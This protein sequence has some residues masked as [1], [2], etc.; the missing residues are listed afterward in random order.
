[1]QVGDRVRVARASTS[2]AMCWPAY[3]VGLTGVIIE[4]DEED[5]GE[6]AEPGVVSVEIDGLG[7]RGR[8]YIHECD[9]ELGRGVR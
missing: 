3:L 2:E 7:K 4:D 9:L 1:M 8:W 6:P 5:Q